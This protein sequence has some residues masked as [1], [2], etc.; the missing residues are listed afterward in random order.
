MDIFPADTLSNLILAATAD[1]KHQPAG[2]FKIL[3]GASSH[4]Q[5]IRIRDFIQY[6]QEYISY[7][8]TL[9]EVTQPHVRAVTSTPLYNLLWFLTQKA[10]VEVMLLRAKLQGDKKT[11]E[12]MHNFQRLLLKMK[13][14]QDIFSH[15][16]AQEYIYEG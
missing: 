4:L 9:H 11:V 5:P 7:Q 1:L 13:E 16:A 3:H 15:F 6:C 12:K 14:G 10:P 2:Y 8:P